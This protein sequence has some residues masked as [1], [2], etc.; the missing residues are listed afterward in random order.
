MN[1][2][3]KILWSAAGALLCA[4]AASAANQL[5]NPGFETGDTT[6]WT[7][8]GLGW[9]ISSGDDAAGGSYGAVC[10]VLHE[11]ENETWRGICQRVPVVPGRA[12]S[13]RADIRAVNIHGA[14][15]WLELQ[16]LD[17]NDA[18]LDQAQ[19]FWI[20]IDQPFTAAELP[21]LV[22]PSNA[23][24]ASIRGIVFVEQLPDPDHPEFLIFDDFGF[25]QR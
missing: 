17:A 18:V 5:E 2:A 7:T 21:D 13:A 6:G 12:Y 15:A 10:D 1:P 9:R 16:W 22:A 4:I 11:H 23:V 8:F 19:S 3:R 14:Q 24:A 25:E 20:S